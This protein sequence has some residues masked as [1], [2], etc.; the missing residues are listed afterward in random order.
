[1]ARFTA[2]TPNPELFGRSA[3]KT[4]WVLVGRTGTPWPPKVVERV[5]HLLWIN[6]MESPLVARSRH[7]ADEPFRP[8]ADRRLD[9]V[10]ARIWS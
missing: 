5:F 7:W 1:M 8:K 6:R 4:R 9:G 2:S 3:S 10:T